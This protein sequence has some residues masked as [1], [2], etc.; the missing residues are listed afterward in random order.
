[1]WHRAVAANLAQL[2][3]CSDVPVLEKL[4]ARHVLSADFKDLKSS[5]IFAT[6]STVYLDV[7]RAVRRRFV[8]TKLFQT[9]VINSM[10]APKSTSSG[11]TTRQTKLLQELGRVSDAE[12]MAMTV[13]AAFCA[14]A[15]GMRIL[16][17]PCAK[18]ANEDPSLRTAHQ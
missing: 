11:L 7:L 8:S 2:A 12:A 9:R 10:I 5:Q 17:L 4:Q 18:E 3:Y 16:G 14:S 13:M 1:M 15:L 6:R